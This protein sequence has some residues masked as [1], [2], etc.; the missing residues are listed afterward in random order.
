MKKENYNEWKEELNDTPELQRHPGELPFEVPE[1]YFD[2]FV[3]NVQNKIA[4]QNSRGFLSIFF[5]RKVLIPAFATVAIAILIFIVNMDREVEDKYISMN[6][7]EIVNSGLVNDLDE[8]LLSE[9]AFESTVTSVSEEEIYLIE[10]TN[11]EILI[12]EL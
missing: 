11:E 7:D 2:S 1:G 9:Y 12:N 8:A 10:S 5:S 3:V 4:N 6:Y